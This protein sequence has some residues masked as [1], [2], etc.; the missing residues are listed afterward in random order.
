MTHYIFVETEPLQRKKKVCHHQI[1]LFLPK[2]II[3]MNVYVKHI[4]FCDLQI[5]YHCN[6]M[7]A[8]YEPI[9][10]PYSFQVYF[11]AVRKIVW[12]KK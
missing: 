1:I 4:T 12:Y 7:Q 3:K 2:K 11:D 9:R 10:N 6:I 8:T 5:I